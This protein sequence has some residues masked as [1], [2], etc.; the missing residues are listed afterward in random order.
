ME[1]QK[2]Q[3]DNRFLKGRQIANMINDHFK[4]SGTR[5]A[6]LDFKDPLRVQMKNDN[7]QGFDTK[8]SEV[9]LSMSRVPDEDKKEILYSEQ[10]Q[11]SEEVKPLMAVSQQDTVQKKYRPVVLDLHLLVSRC[12]EQKIRDNHLNARNE[13]RSPQGAAAWKGN[14]R[15][16][17]NGNGEETS[18]D[19][20]HGGLYIERPVF[21]RRFGQLQQKGKGERRRSRSTSETR[22]HAKRYGKGD[23]KGKGTSPSSQSKKLVCYHCQM[24][25]CYMDSAC[26][27]WQL[28]PQIPTWMLVEGTRLCSGR[29][30]KPVK[31]KMVMQLWPYNWKRPKD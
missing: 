31:T 16:N 3:Q 25:Q 19:R 9:R 8:W 21:A 23:T 4:I 1:E 17:P 7:V 11:Y 30:A 18:E 12:V 6:F 29:Q 14:P 5:E 26:D 13:D 28:K 15:G 2:A 22:R 20:K 10:L 24:E 27:Y